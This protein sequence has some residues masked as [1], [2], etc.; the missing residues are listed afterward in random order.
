MPLTTLPLTT[1]GFGGAVFGFDSATP[2]SDSGLRTLVE[3]VFACGVVVV[4]DQSIATLADLA[5][6]IGESEVVLP[7]EHRLP[8]SSTLR[9]QTNIPGLGV[10]GGGMYWHADGSWL[11]EATDLTLLHCV[12]A[13]GT[14]GTT[15]FVDAAPL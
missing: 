8:G 9:L 7:A 6:R 14:G 4:R 5:G 13:P 3:A 10:N 15:A 2:Q 11:P 12:V 1:V